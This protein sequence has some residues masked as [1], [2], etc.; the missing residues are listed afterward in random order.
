MR[1]KLYWSCLRFSDEDRNII[2]NCNLTQ[3]FFFDDDGFELERERERAMIS[4]TIR[5][6]HTEIIR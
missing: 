5:I 1:I 3:T 4:K 6:V 2:F